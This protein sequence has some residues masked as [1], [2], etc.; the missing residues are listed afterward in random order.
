MTYPIPRTAT[1]YCQLVEARLGW[2]PP[3]G[4]AWS[5]YNVMAGRVKRRMADF[6][7]TFADLALAV[8]L[9]VKEK[10]P[11]HP[12]GVFHAVPIARAKANQPEPDLE[13]NIRA[14]IAYETE[15][16][17]PAGWVDRLHRAQG[18]GRQQ[19]LEDWKESVR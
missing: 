14:A 12:L 19:A 17:D 8:E 2:L 4:P 1:E 5:R 6:D 18:P 13:F 9:C 3:E 10:R 16:G 15:R 7:V 11:R